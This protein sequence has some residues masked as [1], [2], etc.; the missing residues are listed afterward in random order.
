[1]LRALWGGLL[2]GGR[3]LAGSRPEVSQ[4]QEEHRISTLQPA[5]YH[6]YVCKYYLVEFVIKLITEQDYDLLACLNVSRLE[7]ITQGRE[8]ENLCRTDLGRWI[9]LWDGP[10]RL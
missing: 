4:M 10:A 1:M 7:Q 3:Q 8:E 2:T 5:F 9:V 6:W